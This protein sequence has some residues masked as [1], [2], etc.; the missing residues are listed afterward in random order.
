MDTYLPAPALS[1][2]FAC[3]PGQP[4]AYKSLC[5]SSSFS[6]EV[7]KV[8]KLMIFGHIDVIKTC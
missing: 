1:N 4:Q 5:I 8:Q 2:I 3:G 6:S 7:Q